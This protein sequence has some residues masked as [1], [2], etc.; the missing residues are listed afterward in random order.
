MLGQMIEEL[1]LTWNKLAAVR[2]SCGVFEPIWGK[3]EIGVPQCTI[4]GDTG[5]LGV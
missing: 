2:C 3:L 4:E 5:W 1:E